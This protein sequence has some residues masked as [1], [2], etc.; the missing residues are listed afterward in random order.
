M[1]FRKVPTS[2]KVTV[3]DTSKSWVRGPSGVCASTFSAFYPFLILEAEKHINTSEHT[4]NY[5]ELRKWA[6]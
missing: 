3:C 1:A 5:Q 2:Q 6:K 4:K